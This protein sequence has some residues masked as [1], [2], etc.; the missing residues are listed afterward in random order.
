MEGWWFK[1]ERHWSRGMGPIDHTCNSKKGLNRL[2]YII[3]SWGQRCVI[4]SQKAREISSC[5]VQESGSLSIGKI[6]DGTPV[7]ADGLK[8]HRES[9]LESRFKD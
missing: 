5:S 3:R 1:V 7:K 9:P 8:C 4:C 6:K 2:V